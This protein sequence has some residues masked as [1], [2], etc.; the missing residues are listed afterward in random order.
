MYKRQL[1]INTSSKHFCEWLRKRT[2]GYDENTYPT[3]NGYFHLGRAEYK[4]TF[5]ETYKLMVISGAYIFPKKAESQ[6]SYGYE[7]LIKVSIQELDEKRLVVIFE[8]HADAVQSYIDYVIDEINHLWPSH[9][10]FS[11]MNIELESELLRITSEQR[12]IQGKLE[13]IHYGVQE[14][15]I[16]QE[17]NQSFFKELEKAV[18]WGINENNQLIMN[19]ERIKLLKWQETTKSELNFTGKLEVTIP[20][21]PL[22]L[23]YKIE[24]E[25]STGVNINKS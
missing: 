1:F 4:D 24:I 14:G 5:F 16:K 20:I 21:I 18:L 22:L 10:Y 3:E 17:E 19:N 6:S 8:T 7:D 2:S 15:L 12:K 25:Q 9:N 13:K 23:N 11:E